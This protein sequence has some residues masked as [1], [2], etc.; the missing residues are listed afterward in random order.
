[1]KGGGK[2]VVRGG[3]GIFYETNIIGNLIF[4]RA[5]QLPPGLGNDVPIINGSSPYL[6]DP[7]TGAIM[8]D[9]S[10]CFGQPIGNCIS[11]V[12]AAQKHYQEVTAA[13]AAHWPPAGVPPLFNQ[14]RDTGGTLIDP[15]YKTPYGIQL[16]LGVQRE[17]RPGLVI[18]ADYVHNRGV[19]FN[20]SRDRNRLGA[21]NTLHIPTAQAAIA[22]ALADCGVAT[23]DEAIVN[24]P[25]YQDDPAIPVPA[26]ISNFADFGLGSGSGLDGMAFGGMNRKFRGMGV[27]ESNGLSLYQALQ[28]RLTGNLPNL[29]PFKNTTTNV[30]YAWG[31]YQST[32][33]DQ[34]FHPSAVYNDN[35]TAFFG[36]TGNDRRHIL[37]ISF[38]TDLPLNFRFSTITA[39]RSPLSD[40]MFLGTVT[41]GADEVFYTDLNGDGIAGDPL[42]GT[43][44]GA[45][46]RKVKADNINNYINQFNAAYA[47]RLTP[48]GQAL[49][50]AGLFTADQLR[51][52]GAVI[53]AV[54]LAPPN[55][56]NEPNYVTTDFR[57]SRSIKITE[58]FS[59]EPQV[60]VFNVFNIANYKSMQSNF[61]DG[62][63]GSPNGTPSGAL[64]IDAGM[65]RMGAGSGS[66]A[67]GIPRAFQFNLR[68]K[69]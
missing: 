35:P 56:R 50:G 18:S 23:I 5:L 11:Q 4:D 63:I 65:S 37:G 42:P 36:T 15:N 2:T 9:F 13:L 51:A 46:G 57:L 1:V 43:N 69:F 58:R 64:P 39:I 49:V 19:H 44:R 20:L 48:A 26:T 40:S 45:F 33:D 59:I 3:A 68:L 41:G 17:L 22:A 27:L 47:G 6:L 62:S 31:S 61:L 52:L 60:E 16:N 54:P 32:G 30:T 55:Q 7:G 21:A 24:C 10:G 8:Y 34:D 29:G 67:A 38:V 25:K 66:F 12:T 53:P 14:T 28:L